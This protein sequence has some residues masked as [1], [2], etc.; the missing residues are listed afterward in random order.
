MNDYRI[1]YHEDADGNSVLRYSGDA[2]ALIDACAKEVAAN[3]EKGK[4]RIREQNFGRRM[5]CLDPVV[6]M[7]VARQNGITDYFDPAIR[8]IMRGRDYS[9]FR[10][11]EDTRY[12]KD[13]SRKIILPWSLVRRADKEA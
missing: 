5:M 12:F 13:R 10:T 11:A 1:S 8:K 3:R 9:K 7:E 2:S 6:M 4:T